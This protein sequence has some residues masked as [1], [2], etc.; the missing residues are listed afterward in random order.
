MDGTEHLH[1]LMT[2]RYYS[3]FYVSNLLIV[4]YLAGLDTTWVHPY[5]PSLALATS[6]C[7]T[8]YNATLNEF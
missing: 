1:K 6:A 8:T 2:R 3:V 4:Y 5:T 7:K